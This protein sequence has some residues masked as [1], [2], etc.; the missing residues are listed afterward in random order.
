[1]SPRNARGSSTSANRNVRSLALVVRL[2]VNFDSACFNQNG[3]QQ[4]RT[5]Y[6]PGFRARANL[7]HSCSAQRLS[8]AR[9]ADRASWGNGGQL[10]I[11]A[12]SIRAEHVE[13][14]RPTSEPVSN[15]NQIRCVEHVAAVDQG[16]REGPRAIVHEPHVHEHIGILA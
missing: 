4:V 10:S 8:P 12:H 2:I 7:H 5:R 15:G 13:Y 11:V 9:R 16:L 6:M 1:M 14:D 3:A